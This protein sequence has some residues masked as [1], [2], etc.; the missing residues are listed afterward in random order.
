MKQRMERTVYRRAARCIVLSHAFA[1]ILVRDYAVARDRIRVIPGGVD[2]QKFNT[3]LSRQDARRRLGWP[4]DRPIVLCVRRLVRRMGLENLIDA[5]EHLRS[6]F[7]AAL[8]II[9]GTGPLADELKQKVVAAGLADS[10]RLAGFIS[11]A[12]LPLAF[13][14]ADLSILPTVSLEG[15]GLVAAESLAAGTPAV[16]T[17]VG[18]LPEVVAPLSQDLILPG[19]DA[20]QIAAYL[21]D[22]LAGRRV[23]PCSDACRRYAEQNFDWN[24][25]ARQ[26]A[27][28]YRETEN[29][30]EGTAARRH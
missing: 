7:P 26:V 20:A 10:V 11:D 8:I 24:S 12:D 16:V 28:V 6:Q 4:V 9:G 21:A 27:G 22:I 19:G 18:G 5:A 14:A 15:F 23:L 2:L 25:V 30:E 17:R 13:R 1:D 29:S 3:D